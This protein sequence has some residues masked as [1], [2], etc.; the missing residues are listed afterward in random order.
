MPRLRD[1]R[2]DQ[3]EMT[4]MGGR[5]GSIN[6]GAGMAIG[7]GIGMALGVALDNMAAGVS[8]GIALGIAFGAGFNN[9]PQH[10]DSGDGPGEDPDPFQPRE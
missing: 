1:A 6:L 3:R 8:I 9:H 2:R 7:V 10:N 4:V 5:K